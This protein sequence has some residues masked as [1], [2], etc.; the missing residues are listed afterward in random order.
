MAAYRFKVGDLVRLQIGILSKEGGTVVDGASKPLKGIYEVTDLVP[1]LVGEQ[2]R[3][4][5]R[6]CSSQVERVVGENC[7][8]PVVRSAQPR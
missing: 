2:P 8:I 7:L 1:A 4:R 6:A 5:I 3:Y